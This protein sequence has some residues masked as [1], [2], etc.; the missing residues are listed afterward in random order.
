MKEETVTVHLYRIGNTR[1]LQY[2][3]TVR[4]RALSSSNKDILGIIITLG[5]SKFHR[6]TSS[7]DEEMRGYPP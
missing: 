5:K 7:F 2:N 3:A 1:K 6:L 4:L